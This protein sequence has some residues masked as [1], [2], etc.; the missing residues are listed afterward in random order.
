MQMLKEN[1][2]RRAEETE[3]I[4][5]TKTQITQE[6]RRQTTQLG[7]LSVGTLRVQMA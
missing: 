3:N 5:N 2:K 7:T 6:K 4:G 1:Q